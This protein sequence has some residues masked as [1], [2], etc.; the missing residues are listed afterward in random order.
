MGGH[1]AGVPQDLAL[2]SRPLSIVLLRPS[3]RYSTSLPFPHREARQAQHL[4]WPPACQPG[5]LPPTQT[6]LSAAAAGVRSGLC[7]PPL[8]STASSPGSTLGALEPQ[9]LP[10]PPLP[11]PGHLEQKILQVLREAGSPVKAAQL[12]KK[13][14][15]SKKELNQV[16]YRM[17]SE[18]KVSLAG[19]ATWRLEEAGAADTALALLAPPSQAKSPPEGAAGVPKKPGPQLSDQQE[20]IYR[21]LEDE[22][23]HNA[24]GIAQALGLRTAKDVNP[25]LYKMKS[26][27]LLDFNEKLKLWAIYRPEDSGRRNQLTARD[28][29][30]RNQST[31]IMKQQ[32]PVIMIHQHGMNSHIS[33]ANSHNT[34]IGYGNVITGGVA[35]GESGSTA[36]RYLPP[37]A[38]GDSSALGA[39]APQDIH[40]E[41]SVLRQVQLGHDNE[42]H[43]HSTPSEGSNHIPSGSPPVS[44]TTEGL[45]ASFEAQMP[46]P[47]PHAPEG[48]AAQRVHIRSCFLEAAAIGNSNRMTVSLVAGARDGEPEEDAEP[49]PEASPSGSAF[50]GDAGQAGPGVVSTITP[51]LEAV[52]LGNRDPEPAE[53]SCRVAE[54]RAGGAREGTGLTA[55]GLGPDSLRKRPG[56]GEGR[57]P[58]PGAL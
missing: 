18:S 34:Q 55:D 53:R 39:W 13:C 17:K 28:S 47:G 23:P 32:S 38:P 9:F 52:T 36:P 1:R 5:S 30:G 19:P 42:L 58:W 12:V 26:K 11:V 33:I 8:P 2:L 41:R 4:L 51:R 54:P 48:E 43:V 25:D 15:V 35:P 29:G 3:T 40:M 24:L 56:P 46:S 45:G 57:A 20:E 44:A 31:A 27:H 22:G 50:R 16:L 37:A 21:F 49:A 6:P 7:P 10:L 14:Q